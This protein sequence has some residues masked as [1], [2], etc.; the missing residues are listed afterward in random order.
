MFLKR[1]KFT[2]FLPNL[3]CK[4]NKRYDYCFITTHSQATIG[5]LSYNCLKKKT[6]F[7]QLQIYLKYI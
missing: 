7:F 2:S 1:I 6:I 3:N 5:G 4:K